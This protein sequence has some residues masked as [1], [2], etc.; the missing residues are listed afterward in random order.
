MTDKYL[1]P[2]PLARV[3]PPSAYSADRTAGSRRSKHGCPALGRQ[4]AS[5]APGNVALAG[6]YLPAE[7]LCG[8][9]AKDLAGKPDLIIN[10]V[11]VRSLVMETD[12]GRKTAPRSGGFHP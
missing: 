1:R 10:V 4:G 2:M 6:R 11:N 3:V 9:P 7:P 8:I 12:W 5:S